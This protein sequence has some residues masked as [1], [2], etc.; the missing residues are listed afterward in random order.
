MV[1]SIDVEKDLTFFTTII[2]KVGIKRNSCNL[3][4]KSEKKYIFNVEKQIPYQEHSRDAPVSTLTQHLTEGFSLCSKTREG[5]E[6][7]KY[8]LEKEEIKLF[9]PVDDMIVYIEMSKDYNSNPGTSN[10]LQQSYKLQGN[11]E[12][13][14]V[15]LYV[16]NKQLKFELNYTA[17]YVNP[18]RKKYV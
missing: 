5:K 15:F 17:I 3:T 13:S 2:S 6:K 16:S 10:Q 12:K 4:R 11:I 7:K 18:Q 8:R 9:L 1:I 14:I